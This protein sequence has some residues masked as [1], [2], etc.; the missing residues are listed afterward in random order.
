MDDAGWWEWDGEKLEEL[1]LCFWRVGPFRLV[2]ELRDFVPLGPRHCCRSKTLALGGTCWGLERYKWQFL[3][4]YLPG[5][6]YRWDS[7][8]I[9]DDTDVDDFSVAVCVDRHPELGQ[10][11]VPKWIKVIHL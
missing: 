7:P 11:A 9:W 1:V 6:R 5:S 8:R 3:K 10:M 2:L 4:E